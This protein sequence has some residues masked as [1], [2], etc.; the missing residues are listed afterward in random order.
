MAELAQNDLQYQL[1]LLALQREEWTPFWR[2]AK[3]LAEA[4]FKEVG[5][6]VS[7]PR[8]PFKMDSTL[9]LA[10]EATGALRIWTA[11]LEGNLVAYITWM[12]QYDCESEGLLI[13]L[14]GGWFALPGYDAGRTVWR[15]SIAALRAEGV[16]AAY[17]HHRFLGRGSVLGKYFEREGGKPIHTTYAFWLGEED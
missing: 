4:H 16:Q 5:Q 3:P 17:A 9:M 7:E 12:V 14:M 15:H 8:R 11:R 10:A 6:D 1:P 13:A 2:D